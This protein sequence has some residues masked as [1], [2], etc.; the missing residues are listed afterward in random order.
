[1]EINKR[2]DSIKRRV[3]IPFIISDYC[4]LTIMARSQLAQSV[5][6]H[7]GVYSVTRWDDFVNF[8]IIEFGANRK[9][10]VVCWEICVIWVEF[11]VRAVSKS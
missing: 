1:M 10:F 6:I 2:R 4:N 11:N 3:E 5:A 8:W 7:S 9:P